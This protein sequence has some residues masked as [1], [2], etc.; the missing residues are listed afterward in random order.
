MS[1]FNNFQTNYANYVPTVPIA[2]CAINVN[3]STIFLI[4]AWNLCTFSTHMELI[5]E[6]E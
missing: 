2:G 5:G 6:G 4:S 1:K 3:T